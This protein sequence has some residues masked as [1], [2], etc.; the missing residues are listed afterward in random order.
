MWVID[1]ETYYFLDSNEAATSLYGYTKEEFL[2]MTTLDIMPEEDKPKFLADSH[3]NEMKNSPTS[4]G[5]WRH[6]KKNGEILTVEV[7]AYSSIY[8]GKKA[9][10]ILI[11]DVTEVKKAE[12]S[13]VASERKF[14]AL[15]ESNSDI[16]SMM[17]A[18]GKVFYRSPSAFRITGWTNE[19]Y[20]RINFFSEILHLEDRERTLRLFADIKKRPGVPVYTTYRVKHKDGHYL[21]MEVVIT[22]MLED[23]HIRAIVYNTKDVT[24][25]KL[26]EDRLMRNEMRFRSLIENNTDVIALIDETGK[27]TYGSPSATRVTGWTPEEYTSPDFLAKVLHPEE[28]IR[29]ASLLEEVKKAPGKSIATATRVLHKNGYYIHIEGTMINLLQAEFIRAIVFNYRDV[30]E[31]KEAEET[32]ASSEK[33]FRSM[34]ENSYDIVLLMDESFR[35]KYRSPSA[36]RITGN[37]DEEVMNTNALDKVHPEDI[38][39][40]KEKMNVL[41]DNPGRGGRALFRYMDSKGRYMWMEGTAKNMLH[42]EAVNAIV[43]NYRDVTERIESEKL[44]QES[45]ERYRTTLDNMI[46]G[47]QIIG[48]DWR[49]K[50]VN[51]TVAKQSRVKKEDLLGYTMMEKFPGI[52]HSGIF[53]AIK[54]CFEDK[55]PVSMDNEFPYPDGTISSFQLSI[56][57]VPEGVFILSVDITEKVIAEK[58]LQEEKD[59]LAAIALT[60]PGLIYSFRLKPDGSM[61]F[62]YA[63]NAIEDIFGL[64][65]PEVAESIDGILANAV[66][67]DKDLVVNSIMESART[68]SPWNIEFRYHHPHRGLI[69]LEGNSIPTRETDGSIIWFGVIMDVTERKAAEARISEQRAQLKTLSDNLPGLMIYQISGNSFTDRRFTYLSSDV[70]R[71]TGKTPEEV[72]E[73][74]TLLYKCISAEDLPRMME[75]ERKSYENFSV[76]NMEVRFRTYKGEQ[77]WLNLVSVPRRNEAGQLI[78]DGFHV[79]ITERKQSQE[80]IRQS[81]E[82]FEM[83]SKATKD[84]VWEYHLETGAMWWNEN[85]YSSFGYDLSEAEHVSTGWE[86]HI[87]P[88][89]KKRVLEEFNRCFKDKEPLWKEE[90]RFIKKNG[91]VAYIYDCG[92]IL[93]DKN[94]KPYKVVGSMIDITEIT[95]AQRELRE[96]LDE[97]LLLTERLSKILNTL[98]AHIAL[99]DGDGIIVDVNEEW[100]SFTK[101]C[102]FAGS[103]YGIGENYMEF[104]GNSMVGV[105]Q[106]QIVADGIKHVLT[107]ANNEFVHEYLCPR[108]ERQRWFKMVV[109][110]LKGKENN[111]A[112]V[113]HIDISEIKRLEEERIKS[114]TEE[115]RKI[116]EAMLKGQEKERNAIGIELHDNVNQILVGTK[117]LLS[118]VRDFPEKREELVP[119][120]IDNINLAIQENRKIAHELVTPNLSNEDLIKQIRRLGDTMLGNAQIKT[121]IQHDRFNEDLLTNDMKLAIYRVA[122]EQCTNIIKYAEAGHVIF[123]LKTIEDRFYMRITDDGKGMDKENVTHGIGL[124]NIASRLGVFGGVVDVET[125]PGQGFSLEIEIPL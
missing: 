92:Y 121:H 83:V 85:Y 40:L 25:R 62:P 8:E 23:E 10:L 56:Q 37:T 81:N 5:T 103:N 41:L 51:D 115:Q 66:Q 73:D 120:C 58:K 117:V 60:A 109:T 119:S 20:E 16:V 79:D 74:P 114:K 111:G 42:E 52:E 98:P 118:V 107:G 69:W 30:T 116:T 31:R 90:Y 9:R 102:R 97:N 59:K 65:L 80:E 13:L 3:K 67:D 7:I 22:N 125:E 50:Y 68:L 94:E 100:K 27:F 87:H 29:I 75:E 47:V 88:D 15:I 78:W 93:Y 19:E 113:M 122:Q 71:I 82:R 101:E 32:L 12:A 112:V 63:S 17:D 110:P 72:M 4:R 34:I 2:K 124:K 64:T 77:K 54:R 57:P 39:E 106:K 99:L 76:F 48:R 44:I 35:I 11:N 105:T 86:N 28:K 43:F 36:I 46:E 26:A 123:A 18:D 89:D 61:G 104:S 1:P 84:I 38:E 95:E 33:R 6:I 14:R 70:T 55:V 53:R 45:E 49:Y 96:S 24:K 108:S 21:D 91:D